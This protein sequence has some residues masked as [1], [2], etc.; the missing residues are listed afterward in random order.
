MQKVLLVH[1]AIPHSQLIMFACTFTYWLMMAASAMSQDVTSVCMSSCLAISQV[2]AQSQHR[3]IALRAYDV[4]K[5]EAIKPA[6]L[7][8][9]ALT[10]I[11][12][13]SHVQAFKVRSKG[14]S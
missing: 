1:Q 9:C 5:E 8:T 11:G 14:Q 13:T 3:E 6:A 4:L 12:V 7:P 2:S 10:A